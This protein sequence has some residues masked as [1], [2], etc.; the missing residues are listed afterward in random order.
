MKTIPLTVRSGH[1]Q[2]EGFTWREDCP[3]DNLAATVSKAVERYIDKDMI[4]KEWI[5]DVEPTMPDHGNCRP[6]LIFRA[7]YL[8]PCDVKMPLPS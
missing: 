8:M 6:D 5:A 4:P 2:A 7:P 1:A 3:V